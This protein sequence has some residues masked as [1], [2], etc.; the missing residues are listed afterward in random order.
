MITDNKPTSGKTRDEIKLKRKEL[1]R[2]IEYQ[3]VLIKK[4]DF[5]FGNISAYQEIG[6]LK[7]ELKGINW[8]LRKS[9]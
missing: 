4:G 3:Y 6:R 5:I 7:A 9:K 2:K 1:K 8:V